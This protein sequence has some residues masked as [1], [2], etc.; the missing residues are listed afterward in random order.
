MRLGGK[1]TPYAPRH[2]G[3]L[4][5]LGLGRRNRLIDVELRLERSANPGQ[6][7]LLLITVLMCNPD[8]PTA[9]TDP[10]WRAR[11]TQ[12][13]CDLRAYLMAQGAPSTEGV[14]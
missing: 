9:A 2:H 12:V 8:N 4:G 13:F 14:H 5:W 1:G 3:P 6:Q 7:S 10:V 11:C